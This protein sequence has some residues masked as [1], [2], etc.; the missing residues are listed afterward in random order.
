MVRDLEERGVR[1]HRWLGFG[2]TV[3][4]CPKFGLGICRCQDVSPVASPDD[5]KTR[6]GTR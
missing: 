1:V 3:G 2:L 4:R 6:T 5:L